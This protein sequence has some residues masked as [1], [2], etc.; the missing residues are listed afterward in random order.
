MSNVKKSLCAN[1]VWTILCLLLLQSC[2]S[3]PEFVDLN[4]CDRPDKVAPTYRGIIQ[5]ALVN[6]PRAFDDC[7]CK[8]RAK[9]GEAC[10]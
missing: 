9:S 1:L 2:A 8:V 6:Q 5:S 10:G 4:H 3:R 7:E